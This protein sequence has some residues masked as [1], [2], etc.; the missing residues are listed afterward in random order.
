MKIEKIDDLIDDSFD[1][2][3]RLQEAIVALE[4]YTAKLKAEIDRVS[5]AD[6]HE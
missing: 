4:E 6:D 2:R 5:G 1:L 3:N